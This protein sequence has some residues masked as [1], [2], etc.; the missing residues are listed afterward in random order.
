MN[1]FLYAIAVSI[2]SYFVGCYSTARLIAKNFKSLNIYKVGNGNPDTENIYNNISA[3]LGV[4]AG[5]VDIAK[6]YFYLMILKMIQ[7][8][9]GYQTDPSTFNLLLY[10]FGFFLLLGHCLPITHSFKGGRG[11]FNY[12]GIMLFFIPIPMIIVFIL[13]L[14]LV[15]VFKQV[16]FSNYFMVLFPPIL[17]F[18]WGIPRELNLMMAIAAMFMGVLNFIVSKKLGEI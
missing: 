14:V 16:R 3:P 13:S 11:L 12:T 8:T 5:A 9:F 10:T 1:I 2:I 6:V 4:F 7:T 15:F 18:F 17:G